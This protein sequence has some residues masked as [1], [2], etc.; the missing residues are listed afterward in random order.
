MLNR[1]EKIIGT[2]L[3]KNISNN[4]VSAEQN[5]KQFEEAKEGSASVDSTNRA[6]QS[7]SKPFETTT[8]IIQ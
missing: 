3:T 2:P 1:D 8:G 6:S 4:P 5:N 7:N